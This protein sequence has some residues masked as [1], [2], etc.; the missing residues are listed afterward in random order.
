[1]M[2]SMS[3]AAAPHPRRPGRPRDVRAEGAIIDAVFALLGEVGFEGLTVE[4]VA[5]R[6]GVGK[7]T[8]YRRWKCRDD[9]VH[10]ALG[11]L[12]GHL[13]VQDT[14]D[15][16]ADLAFC[17]GSLCERVEAIGPPAVG[18]LISQGAIDDEL[19][20]LV[21]AFVVEGRQPLRD[22]LQQAKQRGQLR[23]DVDVDDGLDMLAG[24]VL[25][26]AL[27][28]RQRVDRKVAKRLVDALLVPAEDERS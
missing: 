5:A 1:M 12:Q 19:G 11:Q 13:D 23:P 18:A 25:F 26:K 7:A 28:L 4:A 15:V 17:L 22:L 6:A 3:E 20:G 10:A 24:A 14:G 21:K 2:A 27:V 8:I 9:L 16:A